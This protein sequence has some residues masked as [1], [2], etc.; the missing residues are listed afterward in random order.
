MLFLVEIDHVKSSAPSTPEAGGAFIERVIFPT[1]AR[2]EQLIA[3]EKIVA[4]GVVVGRIAL[5]FILEAE[6]PAHADQIV[7]SL[8]LWVVAE[9]R[10]TPLIGFSE[11]RQHVQ[12]LLDSLARGG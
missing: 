11:R 4:G 10:V 3:D 1:I 8:P 2:A 9:S 6:S 5:R 7:S 12:Q